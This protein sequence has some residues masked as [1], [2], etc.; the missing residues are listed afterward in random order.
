MIGIA[1]VFGAASIFAADIWIKSQADA[2]VTT[3]STVVEIPKQVETATIVVAAQPLRF[4]MELTP[5]LLTEIAWPRE[6][7]P[8]GAF[9][10]SG[11]LLAEGG[12]IV[13]SPMEPNE[14][15]LSA[16]LS[17]PGGKASLSNLL[18]PGMRAVAIRTDEI[19]GVG[20]FITP[21]DRVDVVLTRDAGAIQEVEGLAKGAS[22]STITTEIVVENVRVLSVG[23]GADIRQTS[24]QVAS[25]V[26]VEVTTQGAGKIALARSIGTLSLALRSSMPDTDGLAGLTT[27]GSFG[28]SVTSGQDATARK[29]AAEPKEPK[30]KTVI[31]TRGLQAQSYEVVSPDGGGAPAGADRAE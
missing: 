7:L 25:S 26:T 22:G 14:P 9:Q 18:T 6:R 8:E 17:G 11:A 31:V 23:Q 30:F 28:G 3:A 15:V 16:K 5:E 2:R 4:G 29:V 20:G 24:P 10:T 19:A 13:L 27:I 12:R 1:A 21:G